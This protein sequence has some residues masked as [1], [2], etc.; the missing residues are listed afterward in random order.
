M[1]QVLRALL[2]TTLVCLL[3]VGGLLWLRGD[4]TGLRQYAI[5]FV[6]AYWNE[7]PT[8]AALSM[9]FDG[10]ATEDGMRLQRTMFLQQ[11]GAYVGASEPKEEWTEAGEGRLVLDLEFEKGTREA[12]FDF[13]YERDM[14]RILRFSLDL[15]RS[16]APDKPYTDPQHYSQRIVQSWAEGL[17][18][19]VWE[20]FDT[21][22]RDRSNRDQFKDDTET[23]VGERG[24]LK[25]VRPA[26]IEDDGGDVVRVTYDVVFAES[27]HKAEVEL[28]WDSGRWYVSDWVIEGFELRRGP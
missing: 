16:G 4:T 18:T 20:H 27:T 3:A 12:R 17:A 13:V 24:D 22:V 11:L 7:E 28:T 23:F 1:N 19:M 6:E 8:D 21:S 5:N 26:G 15:P 14:W 10:P 25:E 9:Q 2:I